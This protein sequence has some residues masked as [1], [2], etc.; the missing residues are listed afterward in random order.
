MLAPRD[1]RTAEDARRI[2]EERG[3][4]HI[5]IGLFDND[6]VMLG[7]YMST[8]KF[9]SALEHGFSFCDVV[10]GWDCKDQLYDNI[11]Y[12]GWH[13]GY[14][15]APVRILPETCR[16]IYTEP[17][18]LL[19]IAELAEQAEAICPRGVLKRVVSQYLTLGYEP[20][21]GVEYEFF[22]FNETPKSVREK[23][24]RNLDTIT[25]DW[26]GYSIIRNS[27]HA[28]L[29]QQILAMG[30]TMDFPWRVCIQRPVRV[31][32]KLHWLQTVLCM[33]Q[34]RL[35]CSKHS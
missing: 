3:L 5:K 32:W 2:V 12:T 4:T 1:V 20:F 6:G 15:D 10:M 33:L 21:A 23:G 29:Y 27:V 22:L 30:Q 18:M 9:F 26:F 28:D 31:L 35:L 24:F 34:I 13:T 7:K 25:P 11:E 17:N 16:D 19:F 14:P 8:A